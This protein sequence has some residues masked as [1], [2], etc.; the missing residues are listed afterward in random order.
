VDG[1][2][3]RDLRPVA[4]V[5]GAL[6][7]ALGAAILAG[8][9]LDADVLTRIAPSL[10]AAMPN[11]ALLFLACGVSLIAASG[12]ARRPAA[13]PCAV[14]VVALA[15]ATLLEHLFDVHL[16]IDNPLGLD[17][18]ERP[19]AGRPATHT[20]GAFLLL[21]CCLMVA[22]WRDRLGDL[23]AGALS[24]G[25]AAVVGLA[26]AG[27]LI[28]VGSLHDTATTH[29][30]S[31]H[32]AVGLVIVLVGVF[33]L[34]P[35]APPASWYADS[36]GGE[37]A[38]RRLMAPALVLPVLAGALIQGGIGLGWYGERFALSMMVVV[39]TAMIQALIYGAVG[40]VREHEAI[41]EELERES[42]KNVRR[43]TTLT[44]QAPVG[45]FETDAHG[46]A[47]FV[48]RRWGE[49]TGRS[50][51]AMSAWKTAVHPDDRGWVQ[52]EWG[53]AASTGSEWDAE[54]RFMRPDGKVR[55][56]ACHATPLRDEHGDVASFMGSVLDIT[57]RRLAEERTGLVVSRIAEAV[58]VIGPDGRRLHLND[59]GRALLRHLRPRDEDG[60]IGNLGWHA[61][62]TVGSRIP[63]DQLPGEITRTTGHAVDERVLG[64][65]DADDTV[66]WLR[67]SARTLSDEGP[68]YTVVV[69]FADVTEQR[70]A[71]ARLAEAQERFELAFHHAPI[72]VALVS[73]EGILTRV[74]EALCRMFGYG[75]AK[76]VGSSFHALTDREGLAEDLKQ[77]RRLVAGELHS[78]EMEKRY[79]RA[80]GSAG[81][82]LLSVSLVRG[83]EGEARYFIAQVMDV[84]ERRR[85]E[86]ELRHQADHDTLTG[87]ANRRVF[88]TA[89]SR[90]VA[91]DRRYGDQS[92]LLMID[93]DDF[94]TVNDT[95]GH[96]IG[97]LV[98]QG[99]ANLLSERIRNTD[100]AARL[101]GDEFAVLLPNTAREGAEILAID[102]VQALRELHI[103][104][105]DGK[106]AT[107]TAS[108]GVACSSELPD[109]ADDE[110]L[111]AA[112][113]VA[114][115]RA[116]RTGRDRYAVQHERPG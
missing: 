100:L 4:R 2:P 72:G 55:W 111:L 3:P 49:I 33:A 18:S 17:E 78:Y 71:E 59:A 84:T 16:G 98:L 20:A 32:T 57:D 94:K 82:S 44:S 96:A 50:D 62:D 58:S 68:P 25:A 89:L 70:E 64:F 5:C 13:V 39:V 11:A 90:Q 110:G 79:T 15:G 75:P 66:R 6:A 105:G 91:R 92:S 47:I 41:R 69:S 10:P 108:V 101:G 34:R 60:P 1:P 53:A 67:I 88:A 86:A 54:F 42:R 61:I 30:M 112:A 99:V 93:L 38:A 22:P 14:F 81:W 56:V 102:L 43:F 85:L 36:G 24:T 63:D 8:W 31:L 77:L 74:N 65:P 28:G 29:G 35:H 83:A 46:G 52:A 45:I 23:A 37:A 40:A 48:N 95:L 7:V 19:H 73:M 107:I 51:A 27:Y 97:D 103:D 104:G 113:D 12:P 106:A 21:G 109:D 26:V 115:Y 116:K 114:M 9:G 76:L 80:D 87:I